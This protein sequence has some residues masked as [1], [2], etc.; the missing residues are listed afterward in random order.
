[1]KKLI[2]LFSLAIVLFACKKEEDNGIIWEK[3][4]GQGNA[5]FIETA[6]DSGII[7]CGVISGK[8]YLVKFTKEKSIETEY[9]SDRTGLFNSAWSDQ[10]GY[11]AAGSSGGKMLLASIGNDGNK[12]WDTTIVASFY[13]DLTSLIDEG[14]G[15]FL[16][17]GSASPD[18]SDN[19]DT[20]ILFVRFNKS[21][22]ITENIET[23]STASRFMSAC[24]AAADASGNIYLAL[25]T[26]TGSQKPKAMIVKFNS[27]LQKLWETELYNN[28]DF[29]AACFDAAAEASGNIYV[30]GKTE[31]SN[32]S[33]TLN[34]SFLAS[35]S[36]TGEV[37]WKKYMENSNAGSSV[38]INGSEEVFM[39]NRN[40]L[41]VRRTSSGDGTDTGIVRM[42]IEC[43]S[44]TTDAFGYDMN[45]D[46]DGNILA[47]G[48]L[49]G[50][51]YLALKSSQ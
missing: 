46:Q 47:A 7:G 23:I 9:A 40:C 44:Y 27:S 32:I 5:F 49:G 33:G 25:T 51:F 18:S 30:T 38:I 15:K 21:G 41:I 17:V 45:L 39:L 4:L 24:N 13:L 3:S 6:Q 29:T 43:D 28:P 19:G 12:I 26:K 16:A 36:R 42:Y 11:I 1:M 35:V 31:A 10:S 37:N 14:G 20:E 8:P 50:N 48:S 34:N 22:Q 2:S